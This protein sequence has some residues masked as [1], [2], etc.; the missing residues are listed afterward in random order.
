[1]SLRV[2]TRSDKAL[3]RGIKERLGEAYW[4]PEPEKGTRAAY[5][6]RI[7]CVTDSPIFL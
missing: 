4:I 7:L 2:F 5:R 6:A 3:L 1:M